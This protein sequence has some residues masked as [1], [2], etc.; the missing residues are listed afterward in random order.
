LRELVRTPYI[1][2]IPLKSGTVNPGVHFILFLQTIPEENLPI[3]QMMEEFPELLHTSSMVY[4]SLPPT[5]LNQ[6]VS[7][8]LQMVRRQS[9]IVGE[10]QPT[11]VEALA[12]TKDGD[13]SVHK[14]DQISD[15]Q[16]RSEITSDVSK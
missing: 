16:Y 13:W 4:P 6:I 11:H 15:T 8:V 7:I 5:Q 12:G 9:S 14:A 1:P 10:E 3:P 2:L